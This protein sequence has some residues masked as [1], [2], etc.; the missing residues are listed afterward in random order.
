MKSLSLVMPASTVALTAMAENFNKV[1]AQVVPR[2]EHESRWMASD[3][4]I[5]S[6]EHDIRDLKK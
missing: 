3:N 5:S 2:A 6:L 1:A 4:R